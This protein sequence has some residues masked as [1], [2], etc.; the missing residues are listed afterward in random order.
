MSAV[1]PTTVGL[2]I[3][4]WAC[5]VPRCSAEASRRAD[6]D[7]LPPQRRL[8][9]INLIHYLA[10]RDVD[11]RDEQRSLAQRRAQQPGS[12]PKPTSSQHSMR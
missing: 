12:P 11:L 7:A 3:A 2:L 8:S 5:G 9:P 6:I 1:S 10:L 4:C